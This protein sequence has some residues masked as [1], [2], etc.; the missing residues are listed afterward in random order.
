MLY[1]CAKVELS[2]QRSYKINRFTDCHLH[3][4]DSD[5]EA[6][7]TTFL[8]GCGAW[9]RCKNIHGCR[10]CPF[11]RNF[12]RRDLRR[13]LLVAY[14]DI[15]NTLKRERRWCLAIVFRIAL[16]YVRTA[17][18]TCGRSGKPPPARRLSYEVG[19]NGRLGSGEGNARL[20]C[21]VKRL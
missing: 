13:D 18:P 5:R 1:N 10:S 11:V 9:R 4:H 3:I 21:R 15:I 16:N 17:R 14:T 6:T 19:A 8:L 7:M 12:C 2:S 20:F